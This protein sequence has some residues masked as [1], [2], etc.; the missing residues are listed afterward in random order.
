MAWKPFSNTPD[1]HVLLRCVAVGA[2]DTKMW[3]EHKTYV[4]RVA[5]ITCG[6]IEVRDDLGH[7]R[8]LLNDKVPSFPM[9]T[10]SVFGRVYTA[11]FDRMELPVYLMHDQPFQCPKCGTRTDF[12]ER[13]PVQ[14]H[15]CPR[16]EFH[17]VAEEDHDRECID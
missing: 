7:R 2:P 13:P 15:T 6:L 4:G 1:E 5:G 9:G 14:L 12:E 11:K 3:T 17:F 10:E 8:M 16:C